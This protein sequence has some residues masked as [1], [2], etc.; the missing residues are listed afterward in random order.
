MS[1]PCAKLTSSC[2]SVETAQPGDR[3][4]APGIVMHFMSSTNL[5]KESTR[6]PEYLSLQSD[7]HTP[8]YILPFIY[9]LVSEQ[10]SKATR[11]YTG[12]SLNSTRPPLNLRDPLVKL[13]REKQEHFTVSPHRISGVRTRDPYISGETVRRSAIAPFTSILCL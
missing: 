5:D 11:R 13:R 3:T 1:P 2:N 4:T 12:F 9:L 6:W 10:H 8:G 7:I